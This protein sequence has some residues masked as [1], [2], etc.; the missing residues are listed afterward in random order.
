M[1][2]T[3]TDADVSA[4][5][6]RVADLVA[7]LPGTTQDQAQGHTG[8]LVRKKRYAWLEVDHHGDGRLALWIK[9]ERGEQEALVG[10]D[11]ERYFVPPYLGPSGWVGVRLDP[12]AR[13]DWDEIAALLEAGWRLNAGKRAVAAYDAEHPPPA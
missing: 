12:A 10:A 13:P 4:A 3:W 2:M 1:D 9:A 11:P 8:Y 5:R 6:T 7:G